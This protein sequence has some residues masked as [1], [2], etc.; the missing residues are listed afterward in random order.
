MAWPKIVSRRTTR[1]SPWVEII[2]RGV[3]FGPGNA[4]D[5]YH[6]IAQGDYVAIVARTPEGTIPIVR[7]YR[8]ALE[9][10]TWELPA[11]TL[12][13]DETAEDCCR[14]ELLE[15]TGFPVRAM[16]AL[17]SYAPC[18]ARLSNRIHSFFVETDSRIEQRMP[19]AGIE[20]RLVTPHELAAYILAGEFALQ[21]HLGALLLA[22]MRGHVNFA[23]F[24]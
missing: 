18:T 10:F 24:R 21:L 4:P 5:L 14:R 23:S 6:A 22:G 2:E 19:E 8:P 13:S 7:Q 15:E 17:G 1:V 3:E 9:N 11:G 12:N 16:H 20:V